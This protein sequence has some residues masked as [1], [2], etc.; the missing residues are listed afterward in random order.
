M[1]TSNKTSEWQSPSPTETRDYHVGSTAK[2]ENLGM[3]INEHALDIPGIQIIREIGRGGMGVVI[4]AEV[5][6]VSS[7]LSGV[8]GFV[9]HLAPR[10]AAERERIKAIVEKN[11]ED[12][13]NTTRMVAIKVATNVQG[14][15]ENGTQNTTAYNRI[16]REIL[17]QLQHQ[18]GVPNSP[19][20]VG[21]QLDKQPVHFISK[22][23]AGYDMDK[24]LEKR[25]MGKLTSIQAASAITAQSARTLAY[26]S[27]QGLVHRDVKPSNF[28][29]D[30][31]GDVIILDYGLVRKVKNES[32]AF[33]ME[34]SIVGTALYA[35][36]EALQGSSDFLDAKA[37]VFSL[38]IQTVK[39]FSG[40][41]PY[42]GADF[43]E[44]LARHLKLEIGQ[45]PEKIDIPM[46]GLSGSEQRFVRTK[47]IPMLSRMIDPD[48]EK[49]PEAKE[50]ALF[51][52]AHSY[53]GGM[54][55]PEEFLNPAQHTNARLRLSPKPDE[56]VLAETLRPYA[57]PEEML[58]S[59]ERGA[60]E[61]AELYN[62]L[63]K[64][65]SKNDLDKTHSSYKRVGYISAGIA[66]AAIAAAGIGIAATY[67]SKKPEE[68]DRVT[69]KKPVS[70]T[71]VIPPVIT[72]PSPERIEQP[73]PE[74]PEVVEQKQT[75]DMQVEGDKL[76]K[77]SVFKES[78][79]TFDE[80]ELLAYYTNAGERAEVAGAF[81]YCTQ[82][83]LAS[84]MNVDAIVL[85]PETKN[86]G[87]G[88][89]SRSSDGSTTFL[90]IAVK[91]GTMYVL[92]RNGETRIFST[93]PHLC[94]SRAQ[95]EG[96][97]DVKAKEEFEPTMEKEGYMFEDMPEIS[98]AEHDAPPYW[99]DTFKKDKASIVKDANDMMT[100]H[101]MRIQKVRMYKNADKQVNA[102]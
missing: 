44:T 81:F 24:L 11:I 96:I 97:S 76:V 73:A 65:G 5:Q 102:Q 12:V 17:R 30:K 56:R 54:V 37:D 27:A 29:I 101:R 82:Q 1:D 58:S 3:T 39:L 53:F 80:E 55:T 34:G 19:R 84:L 21:A 87:I 68:N 26:M 23:E 46:N 93:L 52:H 33:T 71:D 16:E 18:E 100:R 38:G 49:R 95:K 62:F 77:L 72:P 7:L 22:Y 15:A 35:A 42:A 79:V 28:L 2:K 14:P 4:A 98:S 45:A 51:F 57:T 61:E 75:L 67:S 86:G 89:I 6:N 43:N 66:A 99:P 32:M 74:T 60:A 85:P 83:R 70:E 13:M 78:P 69:V 94:M 47:L 59:I 41:I 40:R 92:E 36:P 64:Y 31:N 25:G 88:Q 8:N 50:V 20:I 91:K 10:S 63:D 9:E 48:P 90:L